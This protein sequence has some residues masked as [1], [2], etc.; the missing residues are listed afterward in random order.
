M[1]TI[2]KF[3]SGDKPLFFKFWWTHVL[4]WG[5]W[6]PCFG[7]LVASP[8]G[9]KARVGSPIHT[10]LRHMWCMFPEIHIWCK[11]CQPLDSQHGSQSLF[12]HACSN[13][14][15]I[16][17]SDKRT[18]T[19]QSNTPV[20]DLRGCQERAP[21]SK[22][23]HFHAVFCR[24]NRLA[25]PLWELAPA[26]SPGKILDPPLHANHLATSDRLS[27][28]KPLLSGVAGVDFEFVKSTGSFT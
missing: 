15:R 3:L 1:W 11:T 16:W 28:D 4:L 25:H 24:K 19:Y 10:W 5:H 2:I 9:F 21:Q 23:F 27:G 22:F 13:I 14:G 8:L 26:P 7:L 17:A 18:P 6:Y 12:P 20:A